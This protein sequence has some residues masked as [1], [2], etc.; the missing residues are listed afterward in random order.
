MRLFL[1]YITGIYRQSIN[2][3]VRSPK[4]LSVSQNEIPILRPGTD[5]VALHSANAVAM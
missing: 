4:E 2:H 3:D 1:F 5:L